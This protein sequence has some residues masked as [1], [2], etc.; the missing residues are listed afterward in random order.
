LF[1]LAHKGGVEG[2]T[3]NKTEDHILSWS[4]DG[5]AKVWDAKTGEKLFTLTED[6]RYVVFARWNQDESRILVGTWNGLVRIYYTST[7]ELAE[8]AC[9]YTTRNFTWEEWQLYFPGQAYERTCEQWPVHP[10]V[11]QS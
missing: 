5:T 2:A 9:E 8:R 6:G 3:W 7:M 4:G 1:T 10:T 11:P